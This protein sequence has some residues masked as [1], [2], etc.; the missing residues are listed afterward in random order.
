MHFAIKPSTFQEQDME[1]EN[2]VWR[3]HLK[4]LSWQ[5]AT[6]PV[7][8]SVVQKVALL[9]YSWFP[10]RKVL[11]QE[12]FLDTPSPPTGEGLLQGRSVRVLLMAED[13]VL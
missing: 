5:A 8:D 13:S 2:I 9:A 11:R 10:H 7:G 1:W 4:H 12:Q 6:L 3:L